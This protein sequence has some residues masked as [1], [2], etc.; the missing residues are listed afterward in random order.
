[1]Q[2]PFVKVTSSPIHASTDYRFKAQLKGFVVDKPQA[3]PMTLMLT[4]AGQDYEGV[5]ASCTAHQKKL[6]CK[7]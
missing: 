5:N 2:S 6:S 3:G 4:L 1:M 7:P